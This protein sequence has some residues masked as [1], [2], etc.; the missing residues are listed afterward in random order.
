MLKFEE[1]QTNISL[2]LQEDQFKSTG[3]KFKYTTE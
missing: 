1:I 2:D 3:E